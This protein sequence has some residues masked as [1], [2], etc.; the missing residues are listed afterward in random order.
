MEKH[1]IDYNILK[2]GQTRLIISLK[3]LNSLNKL[4]RPCWINFYFEQKF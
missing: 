4:I 1:S 3:R 2:K